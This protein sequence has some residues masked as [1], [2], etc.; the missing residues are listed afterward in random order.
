MRYLSKLGMLGFLLLGLGACEGVVD[1]AGETGEMEVAAVGDEGS[2]AAND[3]GEPAPAPGSGEASSGGAE[4]T[5][6]FR[7]RVYVRSSAGEWIEVTRRGAES[8][9]VK[10]SGTGEAVVIATARVAAGSYDRVRVRFEEVEAEVTSFRFGLGSLLSGSFRVESD[11]SQAA[12]V[13]S[14]A[15]FEVRAGSSARLVMDLNSSAWLQRA[16]TQ[17][18]TVSRADFENAVRLRVE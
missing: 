1:P 15:P 10:A 4:G 3:A 9:T 2:S 12:T 7:A 18:R 16:D 13:E 11:G 6:R 17:T 8:A 5:L 14:A